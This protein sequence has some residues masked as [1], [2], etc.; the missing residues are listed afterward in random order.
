M[1]SFISICISKRS[2]TSL[3]VYN[4]DKIYYDKTVK[5]MKFYNHKQIRY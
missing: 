3:R 4:N 2:A 1:L 5:L